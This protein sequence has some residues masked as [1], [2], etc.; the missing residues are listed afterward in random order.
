MDKYAND[1][2][3]R[4]SAMCQLIDTKYAPLIMNALPDN[5]DAAWVTEVR[6][7]QS[8]VMTQGTQM[9]HHLTTGDKVVLVT[10]VDKFIAEANKT[11]QSIEDTLLRYCGLTWSKDIWMSTPRF[12]IAKDGKMDVVDVDANRVMTKFY[13]MIEDPDNFD[14]DIRLY[15]TYNNDTDLCHKRAGEEY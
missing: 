10:E 3:D 12:V 7:Q 1:L 11:L 4:V 8:R 14:H 15:L 5:T 9:I 13:E 2:Y 6:A